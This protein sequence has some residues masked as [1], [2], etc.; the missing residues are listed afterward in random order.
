LKSNLPIGIVGLSIVALFLAAVP[1]H[2]Q[3]I[4]RPFLNRVATSPFV[5]DA[6][7]YGI[8]HYLPGFPT[9]PATT[10]TTPTT[11][12]STINVDSSVNANLQKIATN[13]K[14]ADD[15]TTGIL[16]DQK[17][18][19]DKEEEDKKAADKKAADDKKK[20]DDEAATATGAKN[21][22]VKPQSAPVAGK[23]G[24]GVETLKNDLKVLM[25]TGTPEM[26][27]QAR[28]NLIKHLQES[29]KPYEATDLINKGDDA[30]VAGDFEA[31]VG[32]YRDALT[33]D[34]GNPAAK[35]SRISAASELRAAEL[36]KSIKQLI[37][38]VEK[39]QRMPSTTVTPLPPMPP[40][41]L[42]P[43]SP[44]VKEPKVSE[45][46]VMQKG[47]T[48][49]P[50]ELEAGFSE[51]LT[52]T[53]F[54][55]DASSKILKSTVLSGTAVIKTGETSC[56]LKINILE[57]P[58]TIAQVIVRITDERAFEVAVIPLTIKK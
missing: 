30:M 7:N 37:Q 6:I 52:V 41:I 48:K 10:P 47:E 12:G 32:F 25:G 46:A 22:A 58:N 38:A 19:A 53:A 17:K 21:G 40:K 14:D 11:S 3:I 44:R 15:I 28:K 43:A 20:A 55:K 27:R 1:A 23:D 50:I 57:V 39:L 45:I 18:R 2:A 33:K 42:L 31:A 8:T 49:I 13:L 51:N 16:N 24:S 4:R 9:L 26:K 36:T 56:E 54:A 35:H 34:P 5:H 29:E